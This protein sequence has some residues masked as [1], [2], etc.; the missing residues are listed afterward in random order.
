MVDT[1]FTWASGLIDQ[2]P[3]IGLMGALVWGILSVLLSPCHLASIPLIV[4]FISNQGAM[5]ARRVFAVSLSFASGILVTIG[6]IGVITSRL[7]RL[8]GDTGMVGNYIVAGVFFI[9]GLYLLGVIRLSIPGISHAPTK[10]KGLLA[11]FV[12]GLIYGI[13]LGPCTFAYMAPIL[14]ILL[15]KSANSLTYGAPLLLFYGIGHCAVIVFAGSFTGLIQRYLDWN[16]QSNG[17]RI[18]KKICGALIILGG[19]YFIFFSR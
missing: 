14:A 15:A 7:G 13:A 19:V 16:E 8:L 3:F 17:L 5:T 11:A 12:L 18:L 6:L 9:V 1:L 4:G 10:R 2:N